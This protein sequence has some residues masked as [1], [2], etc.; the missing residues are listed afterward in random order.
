V[1]DHEPDPELLTR[2]HAADPASSLSAADPR[3]VAQL[4]EAAMSDTRY[5]AERAVGHDVDAH[6]RESRESGT[7][8]RSPLTWLVAAAS[9]VLIA[10][11][12]VI[13][14]AQRGDDSAPATV[15]SVTELGYSSPVGR[16][17]L[18][19]VG[20]LRVQSVAFRGTLVSLTGAVATFDVG[21]WYAG[22]PT[23]TAK[24]SAAA[25]S[26]SELVRSA[27]LT[28]GERYLVAATG[29]NVTGCGFSGP[30]SSPLQRLYDRAFG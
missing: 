12:G 25:P 11:A 26:F 21:R 19:S 14:L 10:G 6:P 13:G 16:C 28:V 5:D 3:R 24:V 8:D 22:G 29:G 23:D 15:T 4:L 9:V 20:V 7:H 30:A 2:F 18:P 1:T 27:D 17:Q